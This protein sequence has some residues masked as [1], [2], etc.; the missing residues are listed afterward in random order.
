M[1]IIYLYIT[2]SHYIVGIGIYVLATKKNK[3]QTLESRIILCEVPF[4]ILK[5]FGV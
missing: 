4:W 2:V 5:S 1:T 3:R